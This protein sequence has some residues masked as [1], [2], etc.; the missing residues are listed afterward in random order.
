MLIYCTSS[1]GKTSFPKNN[2][3]QTG[4]NFI[5][6]GR[7]ETESPDN[8]VALL[9][10]ENIN[11]ESLANKNK[12]LEDAGA[13]KKPKTKVEDLL[14]FG[15]HLNIRGIH[16]AHYAKGVLPIKRENCFRLFITITNQESF[17]GTITNTCSI[18]DLKWKY[19]MIS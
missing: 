19:T 10:L 16:L 17:Y 9:H 14:R 13:Y 18:K 1:S 2:F 15:R 4:S 12:I 5:V 7:D 8:Y 3:D 6:F 11:I